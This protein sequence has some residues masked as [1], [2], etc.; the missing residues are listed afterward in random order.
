MTAHRVFIY[1][2]SRP[3]SAIVQVEA[4]IEVKEKCTWAHVRNKHFLLGATA[5]YT[6]P[7]ANRAKRGALQKVIDT[8]FH[9]RNPRT[10]HLPDNAKRAL[11]EFEAKGQFRG[12]RLMQ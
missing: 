1:N 4:E 6:L 8:P 11:A 3:G 7:S 10:M 12:T 2:P 9:Y 5:F